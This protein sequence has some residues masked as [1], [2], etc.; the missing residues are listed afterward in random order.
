[1]YDS[2]ITCDEIRNADT[3]A[4]SNNKETKTFPIKFN[5]K[6]SL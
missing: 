3:E 1:M 6:N 5:E 2:A 4:K